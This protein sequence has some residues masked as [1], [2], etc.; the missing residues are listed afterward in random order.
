[1]TPEISLIILNH[2]GAIWL[3][4]C[5]ESICAQTAAGRFEVVIFD[6]AS[7]DNSLVICERFR[8]R[9]PSLRIVA[10]KRDLWYCDACNAAARE[11]HS[12]LLLFLNT[13]IWLE[14]NCIQMLLEAAESG[15]E[16][17]AARILDYDSDNFQTFGAA[18]IDWLGCTVFM[19]NH[20]T[21]C[22]FLAG[23]GGAF[24][25]RKDWFEK[26]G[27]YPDEWIAYVDEMDLGWRVWAA[28][29]RVVGVPRAIVHHRGAAMANPAGG[30]KIIELRTT[31]TKR[32]LST[33][34]NI[35]FLLK[36]CQHILLLLLIPHLCLL[37][38]EALVWLVLTRQWQFVKQAYIRGIV[39]AFRMR[40]Q[41]REWRRQSARI[42]RHGD[43]WM[44]RF[45]KLK[46]GRWGEVKHLFKLGMPKVDYK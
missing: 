42:R 29:G 41:V 45:I 33:R 13:D 14:T 40:R 26:I 37:V 39:E 18:G 5:L 36:N 25:I 7:G 30:T 35:L 27:G 31:V 34:N 23:I 19:S 20:S 38:C 22:D 2:N 43:F 17:L 12:P 16:V 4:R 6:A 32:F 8:P 44:L 46:P 28:G 10:D 21:A 11:A 9:L 15:A 24:A 3:D 1:M